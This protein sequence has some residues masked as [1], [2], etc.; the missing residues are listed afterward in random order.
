MRVVTVSDGRRLRVD[1]EQIV[2]H[3]L[4][5]GEAIDGALVTRLAARDLYLR[6]R[7][8]A[9]RILAVRSRSAAEMRARLRLKRIPE[10]L[11]RALLR[12]LG[13]LGYLDDLAFA[14]AWI[15][16]RRARR[17]SG[18]RRLRWELREKGVPG[19]LIDQAL[20]EA[21]EGEGGIAMEERGARTLVERRLRAYRGLTPDRRARRIAGL[22][23]RRGFAP[24]TIARVLR[25]LGR[26]AVEEATDA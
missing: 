23:Q 13:S 9:L 14:R 22:L 24:E 17:P 18:I 5:P 11:I 3:G 15:A 2:R 1:A 19:A 26:S 4:A 6:A 8:T 25:T 12:D 16:G 10:P 7:D 20:R 21:G